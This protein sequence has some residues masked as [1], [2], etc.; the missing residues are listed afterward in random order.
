MGRK[1]APLLS[2]LE[3]KGAADASLARKAVAHFRGGDGLDTVKSRRRP[4]LDG[5]GS[6]RP[7]QEESGTEYDVS[8]VCRLLR[9]WGYTWKVP[10][11]RYVNRPTAGG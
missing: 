8:Y 5:R 10:V 1:V 3:G 6:L 2:R 11:G 7:D 4:M 9:G